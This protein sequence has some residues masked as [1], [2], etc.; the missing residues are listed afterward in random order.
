M[1]NNTEKASET[2][3]EKKKNKKKVIISA[4]IFS[5][6]LLLFLLGMFLILINPDLMLLGIILMLIGLPLLLAYTAIL[7]GPD[8]AKNMSLIFDK[9]YRAKNYLHLYASKNPNY[10]YKMTRKAADMKKATFCYF[11]DELYSYQRG[12]EIYDVTKI[13]EVFGDD[14]I[15][16]DRRKCYDDEYME[17]K[18]DDSFFYVCINMKEKFFVALVLHEDDI[19]D[20]VTLNTSKLRSMKY[21]KAVDQVFDKAVKENREMLR[22]FDE[23]KTFED[24]FVDIKDIIYKCKE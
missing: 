9:K 23:D 17:I 5:V 11:T 15:I 21:V 7:I 18:V 13:N 3:E 10:Y 2:M 20:I 22:T 24:V 8:V 4:I 19:K 12:C 6:L 16:K 1:E 14:F